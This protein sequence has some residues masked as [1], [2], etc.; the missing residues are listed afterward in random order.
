MTMTQSETIQ[1][2]MAQYGGK[3]ITNTSTTTPVGG[4]VFVAI[5]AIE[6]TVIN[7][8]ASN[9][10]GLTGATLL[11]GMTIYGRFTSITLTSGKVIAYNGV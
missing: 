10:S 4:F 5:Q 3:Y 1:S 7:T 11:A 8:S 9:I 6:D 2:E